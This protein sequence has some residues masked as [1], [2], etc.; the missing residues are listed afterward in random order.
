MP[1]TPGYTQDGWVPE[2]RSRIVTERQEAEA[3][4]CMH[5]GWPRCLDKARI[6]PERRIPCHACMQGGWAPENAQTTG[7][8]PMR[9][10]GR[11]E[12]ANNAVHACKATLR[13]AQPEGG[14]PS[15]CLGQTALPLPTRPL[16]APRGRARVL[17]QLLGRPQHGGTP[18]QCLPNG[19]ASQLAA[20][21]GKLTSI[22][23]V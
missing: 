12:E 8:E 18:A 6:S 17:C 21:G 20:K 1:D 5:A 13:A 3:L 14:G 7:E 4:L 9:M 2:R 16:G 23:P 22:S 15:A 19:A 11:R 10:A